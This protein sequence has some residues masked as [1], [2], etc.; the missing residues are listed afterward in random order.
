V[1]VKG[2][3]Q[4]GLRAERAAPGPADSRVINQ[5]RQHILTLEQSLGNMH[6]QVRESTSITN[7]AGT[8]R[9]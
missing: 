2:A 7:S 5:H 1:A 4:C 3:V 9:C 6:P 8:V